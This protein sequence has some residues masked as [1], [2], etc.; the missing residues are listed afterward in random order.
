MLRQL[1]RKK[2]KLLTNGASSGDDDVSRRNDPSVIV[3]AAAVPSADASVAPLDAPLTSPDLPQP[4]A[5]ASQADGDDVIAHCQ[6]EDPF[7]QN[8]LTATT[9]HGN[10]TCSKNDVTG[11]TRDTLMESIERV[12]NNTATPPRD[13]SLSQAT[14]DSSLHDSQL[15]GLT[16]AHCKCS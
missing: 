12:A 1:Q 10:E 16:G 6:N 15:V 3:D 2:Q 8:G 13:V 9:A 7:I 5:L 11:T 14:D 4:A